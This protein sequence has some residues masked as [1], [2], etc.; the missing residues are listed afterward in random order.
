MDAS[1]K[2]LIGITLL[3]TLTACAVLR[4]PTDHSS[5]TPTP[6]AEPAASVSQPSSSGKSVSP[7]TTASSTETPPA[8]S[9]AAN[10]VVITPLREPQT[11]APQQVP[12]IPS[13]EESAAPAPAQTEAA[14]KSAPPPAAPASR[15]ES[16]PAKAAAPAKPRTVVAD[17]VPREFTLTVGRKDPSHPYYGRGHDI[18]FVVDGV[19]GKELVLTRGVTY[20]FHVDTNVQHDF[21]FSTSPY[22]RGAGTLTDGITGQ[23]TYR[24]TVTFTPSASTPD[25][26][27]YEC[28]NHAYMGGKIHIANAGDKVTVG[29]EQ[30]SAGTPKQVQV[31]A[32]QV[33][34]KISY[35]GMLMGSSPIMKR[36]A[37]S[38][39]VQAHGL[40]AQAQKHYKNAQTALGAGDN[41]AAMEAVNESLRL[42][43]AAAH[44]VPD[45]SEQI[46]YKSRY[47]DLYEQLRSF[48][49]SYNK[50]LE[51]GIKP[52]AGQGLDK[53]KF[54][55]LV[56]EANGLADR[57]Q[58]EAA[59]KRLERANEMLTAALGSLLQSQTVVYDKNFATPKEEYEYEL[60]RY[61]SYLE[62]IPLAIEQR[63]P[64]GQTVAMMDK[65][66]ARAKEVRDEGVKLADKGDHKQA[67]LALQ[68]ATE[69][70]QRALRL[71][72]VQ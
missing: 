52:K 10:G 64:S 17:R 40:M 27:Y 4:G 38:G 21:Y 24:G 48:D 51:R 26:V 35:A 49:K 67:I 72:G 5:E 9:A 60:A 68:A 11:S 65:L 33:K 54:D 47:N 39:N 56:K 6:A 61:Q 57:E 63:R 12:P 32:A 20:T 58:Y 37:A 44:L 46:D 41:A 7:Q 23:Y 29:G 30:S 66:A 16:P 31:S 22:G 2:L 1:P 53:A 18:G 50:N 14:S 3:S 36:V 15:S 71:A 43:S 59:T 55:Q 19:Q 34:Q 8:K 28:R 25:V 13:Q 62:L 42:F 70:L 69:R 45:P